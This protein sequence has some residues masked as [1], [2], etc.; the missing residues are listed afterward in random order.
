MRPPAAPGM[1]N[2]STRSRF[3]RGLLSP[4]AARAPDSG[5]S[6]NRSGIRGKTVEISKT[7][8]AAGDRPFARLRDRIAAT[9]PALSRL[10]LASRAMLSLA[11]SETALAGLTL[12]V[13]E[14]PIAA[15]GLA[16]VTSF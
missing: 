13:K 15:Y 16:A 11:I 4:H 9:D 3:S 5:G 7:Y 8:G 10:R 6:P 1:R 14:L 12:V 2:P